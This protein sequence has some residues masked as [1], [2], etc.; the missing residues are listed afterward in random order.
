MPL[1]WIKLSLWT[2]G[3]HTTVGVIIGDDFENYQ[4]V[5]GAMLDDELPYGPFFPILHDI[6]SRKLNNRF[7]RLYI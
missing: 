7:S 3:Y 2:T 4:K 1:L 5:N 6:F